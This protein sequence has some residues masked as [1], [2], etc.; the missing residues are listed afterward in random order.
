[1]T[2]TMVKKLSFKHST[3]RYLNIVKRVYKIV[4]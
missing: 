2:Y 1:M 3:E 4:I